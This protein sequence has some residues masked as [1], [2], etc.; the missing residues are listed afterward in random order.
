MPPGCPACP[1][2][3]YL[4]HSFSLVD[5]VLGCAKIS[6]HNSS[7]RHSAIQQFLQRSAWEHGVPST[8]ASSYT[9]VEN[10]EE[11][12]PDFELQVDSMRIVVDHSFIEWTKGAVR[13]RNKQK[14]NRYDAL[15][16]ADGAT[17]TPAVLSI[18]GQFST[19]AR[20]VLQSVSGVDGMISIHKGQIVD[21][22][23][24]AMS[25]WN[26]FQKAY[27]AAV[28]AQ[29]AAILAT[30]AVGLQRKRSRK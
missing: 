20:T 10:G 30:T 9:V 6:G 13:R 18:H 22:N 26:E 15:V 11:K 12:H 4:A 25:A 16:E 19:E 24:K 14:R 23:Q 7:V 5:H 2:C 27:E 17:F 3:N 21:T 8:T 28:A 1:G 29:N